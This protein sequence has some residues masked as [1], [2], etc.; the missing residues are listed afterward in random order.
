LV[1]PK[2]VGH[3][4][5]AIK[6]THPDDYSQGV[7]LFLTPPPQPQYPMMGV[8][9]NPSGSPVATILPIPLSL[10]VA[11]RAPNSPAT[12]APSPTK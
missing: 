11:A 2:I 9:N 5:D 4:L 3:R 1:P 10:P 7:T 12:A 8:P 6:A